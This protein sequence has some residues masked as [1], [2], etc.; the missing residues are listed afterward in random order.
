METS[1]QQPAIELRNVGVTRGG[2]WILRGIDWSVSAGTCAA[3]LGPNGSGK[4]TLSRVIC[5]YIWPSEG[6]MRVGGARFGEIDLNHLRRSIRLVQ[7]AGPYDADPE[8]SAFEVVLTGQFGTIGLFDAAQERDRIRAQDLLRT[9][10][11]ET[12]RD[13]RYFTLSSGER[14][15]ALIARAMMGNPRLLILDEPT[16]GLDLLARERVLATMSAMQ[17]LPEWRRPTILLITH[18]IEELPPQTSN[19]LL[20]DEGKIA[21]KGVPVD[22]LRSEILSPVYRCPLRVEM[23]SGRYYLKVNP[24]AW[25]EMLD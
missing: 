5:G 9:V 8:L 4:S 13:A 18:H 14:V 2:R 7:S 23:D 12:L 16:A 17:S 19:V 6:E 21:A 22:V 25:P 3:I 10:G 1:A 20:L 15:R 24:S 11:L